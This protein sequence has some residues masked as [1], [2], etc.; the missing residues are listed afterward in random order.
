MSD[1][2]SP[3]TTGGK[4]ILTA[5]EAEQSEVPWTALEARLE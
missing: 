1:A 2:T 4:G 3:Q 5:F